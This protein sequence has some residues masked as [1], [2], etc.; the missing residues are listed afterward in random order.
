MLRVFK[1]HYRL[2]PIT[3][4]QF[5]QLRTQTAKIVAIYKHVGSHVQYHD[6]VA[7]LDIEDQ[8]ATLDVEANAE[9]RVVAVNYGAGDLVHPGDHLMVIEPNSWPNNEQYLVRA[10]ANPFFQ[11]KAQ[12]CPVSFEH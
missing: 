5:T 4:P 1:R 7:T 8:N 3:V 6:T 2:V 9:G 11:K 12:Q 10:S